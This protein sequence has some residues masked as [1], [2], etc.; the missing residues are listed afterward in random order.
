MLCFPCRLEVFKGLKTDT[1]LRDFTVFEYTKDKVSDHMLLCSFVQSN[2]FC[3]Y[4]HASLSHML[5]YFV[6]M[7][8]CCW[9]NQL[10]VVMLL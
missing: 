1:V 4:L 3:K 9:L 8:S 10:F 7:S 6:R 5:S 2:C